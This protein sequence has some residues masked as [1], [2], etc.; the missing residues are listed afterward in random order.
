MD[1]DGG[2][3]TSPGGSVT[4]RSVAA[5]SDV[6]E[7]DSSSWL[8]EPDAPIALPLQAVPRD[9]WSSPRVTSRA[10]SRNTSR[11][12][13]R[14]SSRAARF[15]EPPTF[16]PSSAA[17]RLFNGGGVDAAAAGA[18][19]PPEQPLLFLQLPLH[20]PLTPARVDGS[21]GEQPVGAKD[22]LSSLAHGGCCA[23]RAE[24]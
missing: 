9:G 16:P 22:Y 7:M 17:A 20:V 11:P 13:S 5:K 19:P 24:G 3:S 8:L 4:S 18:E 12:T 10:I 21:R 14:P 23:W 2:G 15:D 6:S 1:V